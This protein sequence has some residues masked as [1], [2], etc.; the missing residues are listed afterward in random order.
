MNDGFGNYL[1]KSARFYIS[2]K[3][4]K[5]LKMPEAGDFDKLLEEKRGIFVTLSKNG[6]LRGCIGIPEPLMSIADGIK[7]ASVSAA[8]NDPRFA[9]LALQELNDITIEVTLLTKP[10]EI[11]RPFRDKIVIG[12]D[13]LILRCGA[14]AG[15][16][17]PQV[18]VE[19]GWDIDEY[20]VQ[21]CFK[22]GL[23]SD[24]LNYPE[25]KLYTFRGTVYKE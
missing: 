18:P 22:A 6:K 7:E 19:Q 9:P 3:I 25:A 24:C 2:K 23:S 1:L 10:V 8:F 16:F 15:L 14:D 17:L 13:G 11:I 12:R 20:L 4:G 5:K 21:I